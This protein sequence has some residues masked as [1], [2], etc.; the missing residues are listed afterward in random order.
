MEQCDNDADTSI[1][2]EALAAATDESV[3]VRAEDIDVLAMLV[4]HSSSTHFSVF[5]TTSNSYD[6]RKIRDALCERKRRYLLFCHAFTGCDTFSAIAGHGKT[7]LFDRLC[8]GD[9][10][11]HMDIFLDLQATKD[12]V[13]KVGIAIFKHIYHGPRTTLGANHYNML[14]R[15]STVGVIKSETLPPTESAAAQHSLRAY[16]Q[17]R[18]WLLLQSMSLDPSHYGRTV[19][20][21]GYEPIPTL[22][23][24]APE[25]LLG[26]T[27]CNCNGDCSNQRCS[28]KKNDVKC[29]SAS[30]NCKGITCKNCAHDDVKSGED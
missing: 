14:S 26:F 13:V 21:H 2:R 3:E 28:C 4:H 6:V 20:A 9:I 17:T 25:K 1:V 11:E 18:D 10:D 7:T 27:T 22:D 19:G 5:L 29:I 15:N 8:G 12:M 24:M 30:G 16:L 23:P